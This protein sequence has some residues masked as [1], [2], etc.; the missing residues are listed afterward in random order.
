MI[1]VNHQ[2]G[3]LWLSLKWLYEDSLEDTDINMLEHPRVLC[4]LPGDNLSGLGTLPARRPPPDAPLSFGLS[5][6]NKPLSLMTHLFGDTAVW[7]TEHK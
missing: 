3:G 7:T 1:S 2:A 4:L 5:K 6:L